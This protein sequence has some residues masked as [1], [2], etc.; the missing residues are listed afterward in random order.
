MSIDS[1]HSMSDMSISSLDN[2]YDLSNDDVF[3]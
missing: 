3:K 2:S 1:F